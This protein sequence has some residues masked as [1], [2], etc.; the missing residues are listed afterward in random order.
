MV[1]VRG[2]DICVAQGDAGVE[3]FFKNS[4]LLLFG[5]ENCCTF[6]SAASIGRGTFKCSEI[7]SCG[8]VSVTFSNAIENDDKSSGVRLSK[9]SMFQSTSC[10]FCG[11]Q[12][13]FW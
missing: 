13:F 2:V 3:V 5:V 12:F 1:G 11:L 8:E 9:D 7:F 6:S 10:C 4:F